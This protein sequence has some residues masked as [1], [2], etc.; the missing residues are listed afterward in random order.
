MSED[1][2]AE[3]AEV[4]SPST[5]EAPADVPESPSGETSDEAKTEEAESPSAK[6]AEADAEPEEWK[7]LLK[8][9]N[10]DKGQAGKAYWKSVN[11]AAALA[12]E[13][14]ELK[15]YREAA[16][17][18]KTEK[19][20]EPHPTLKQVDDAIT[21]L[22]KAIQADL[23]RQEIELFKELRQYEKNIAVL[24]DKVANADITEKDALEVK[25]DNAK[26]R[27]DRCEEKIR[28][29]QSDAEAK[30]QRI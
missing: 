5:E 4:E 9:Y 16:E 8:K 21:A 11:D 2:N 28:K 6:A 13:N 22:S 27:W 29:V 14:K 20:A 10:G 24:E 26:L 1:A 18:A 17:K 15:A 25:L 19:P 3:P 30:A 12:K 23:P 7:N